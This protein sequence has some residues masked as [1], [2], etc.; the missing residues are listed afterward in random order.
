MNSIERIKAVINFQKPDRVPVMPQV[1]GHAATLSGVTLGDYI[2]GGE[3]LAS[4]QLKAPG[5]P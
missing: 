3:L 2:Q 1:F 5:I 4:C